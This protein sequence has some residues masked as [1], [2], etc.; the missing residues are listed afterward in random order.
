MPNVSYAAFGI[1]PG[2]PPPPPPAG[3]ALL[4]ALHDTTLKKSELY[5]RE[6]PHNETLPVK[7]GA[8]WHGVEQ[9]GGQYPT[10]EGTGS[11]VLP[12]PQLFHHRLPVITDSSG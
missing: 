3:S 5:S 6:L 10:T 4:V 12:V 11:C 7:K 9:L 8:V 1:V 2:S